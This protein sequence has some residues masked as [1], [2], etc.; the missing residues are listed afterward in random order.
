MTKRMKEFKARLKANAENFNSQEEKSKMDRCYEFFDTMAGLLGDRYEIV[1]SCN[2]DLSRYLV[3]VG[4]SDQITY[5]GKPEM[6]FR[7]SDHWSW[8]SNLQKC[9]NERYVQCY[10]MDMPNPRPRANPGEG[11]NAIRGYQV[12]IQRNGRYYHVFGDKFDRRTRRWNWVEA[13]PETVAKELG[14]IV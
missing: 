2:K 4:T 11:T 12:C 3:P 5:Y 1:P 9:S 14:L 7:V 13:N 6:S 8:Y 10:S